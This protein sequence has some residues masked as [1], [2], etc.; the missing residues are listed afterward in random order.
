MTPVILSLFLP[1]WNGAGLRRRRHVA[2]GQLTKRVTHWKIILF[3]QSS[4]KFK[5][6]PSDK[7]EWQFFLSSIWL[8]NK[9][10]AAL[11]IF[12][13]NS[14][15]IVLRSDNF[16]FVVCNFLCNTFIFSCSNTFWL[17]PPLH[18]FCFFHLWS[19]VTSACKAKTKGSIVVGVKSYCLVNTRWLDEGS[20]LWKWR[21]V[22]NKE[23]S[24]GSRGVGSFKGKP[25]LFLCCKSLF[26]FFLFSH[27][28]L[29]IFIIMY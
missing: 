17:K 10:Y 21:V 25:L 1:V 7:Y 16:S 22:G 11:K 8:H 5:K 29:F 3:G 24:V 27:F 13:Q 2:K 20:T 18:W 12:R 28:L 23:R 26:T 6:L 4:Q 19:Q 9:G 14:W 15:K